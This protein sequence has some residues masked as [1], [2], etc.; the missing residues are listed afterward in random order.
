MA[1][2]LDCAR[3]VKGLLC[4]FLS[5]HAHFSIDLLL[6]FFSLYIL[7][8][9][10]YFKSRSHKI[11]HVFLGSIGIYL[12]AGLTFQQQLSHALALCS[13]ILLETCHKEMVIKKIK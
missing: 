6:I 7:K 11:S 5:L 12:Y 1:E 10:Y 13:V 4:K 8:S 9:V 2:F 3:L